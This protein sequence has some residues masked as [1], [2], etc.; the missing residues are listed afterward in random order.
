MPA[1]AA[2]PFAA[3]TVDDTELWNL[4]HTTLKFFLPRFR[5]YARKVSSHPSNNSFDMYKKKLNKI[6]EGLTKL[7][8]DFYNP[9]IYN[10]PTVKKAIVLLIH[11]F[12]SFWS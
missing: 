9:K 1:A 6:D 3:L 4:D 12:S 5:E 10:D 8:D 7:E 11:H 2:D